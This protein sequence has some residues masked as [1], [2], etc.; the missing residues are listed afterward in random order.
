MMTTKS[1]DR[2][3]DGANAP[4]SATFSARPSQSARDPASPPYT[5]EAL[6]LDV[7]RLRQ[8][9]KKYR[10]S[11]RRNAIYGFF[12]LI[13]QTVS[14]WQMERRANGRTWRALALRGCA[15]PDTIEPFRDLTVAAAHPSR[16]DNRT[17]A[18]WSRVLRYAAAYKIPGK[19]LDRFVMRRGGIN[20][21]AGLYTR[22]LG[23][24]AT[25]KRKG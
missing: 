13:F 8:A 11:R 3:R 16:I 21:C 9:W 12:D 25:P 2:W 17:L 24:G 15:M 22:R 19:P 5:R 4:V 6:M 14:I 23:R 7:R 20:G 1:Y 18:K 10:K